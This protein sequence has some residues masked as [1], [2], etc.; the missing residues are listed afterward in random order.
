MRKVL[1]LTLLIITLTG[2][3]GKE[4]TN[5]QEKPN[6]EKVVEI[7]EK[8]VI[9]NKDYSGIK[10]ENIKFIY[11]SEYST[12]SYTIINSKS[13]AITIGRYDVVIKDINGNELGK[14]ESYLPNEIQSNESQEV[15][16]SIDKDFTKAASADFNF[17]T[18]NQ[19]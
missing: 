11:D 2:C 17:I 9:E 13:T 1:V 6:K 18:L 16:L 7:K 4:K 19:E 12:M 10:I 5:E 14:L 8:G 15:S 3:F